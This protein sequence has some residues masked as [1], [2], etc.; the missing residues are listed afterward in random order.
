[1]AKFPKP[2]LDCGALTDG[3]NRCAVHQKRIEDLAAVRRASVKKT[4]GTYSGDYRRR[5]KAVRDAAI[6]CH[7]CGEA[8][9]LNDPWEA[10]HLIPGDPNSP[11]LAAHRSCNQSRGNKPL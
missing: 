7:L 2:C 5:A 9:R 4:L 6:L 10:D 1:M 11:L 8:A 3:G